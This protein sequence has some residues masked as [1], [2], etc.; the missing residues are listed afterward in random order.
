MIAD[1]VERIAKLTQEQRLTMHSEMQEV[2]QHNYNHFFGE[3]RSIITKELVV[4]FER[5]VRIHNNGRVDEHVVN[6][7]DY[8]QAHSALLA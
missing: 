6:L 3:F 1:Q 5:C 2:L 8:D 4:N 7:I